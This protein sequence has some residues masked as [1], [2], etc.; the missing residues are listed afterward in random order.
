MGLSQCT[1][2][3]LVPSSV[4]RRPSLLMGLGYFF[5]GSKRGKVPLNVTQILCLWHVS[6]HSW[7]ISQCTFSPSLCPSHTY[8]LIH[9]MLPVPQQEQAPLTIPS[10]LSAAVIV[11]QRKPFMGLSFLQSCVRNSWLGAEL[12]FIMQQAPA[13]STTLRHSLQL[14]SCFTIHTKFLYMYPLAHLSETQPFI[15]NDSQMLA[16]NHRYI[17]FGFKT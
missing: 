17:L 16:V 1:R 7:V 11:A 9:S 12:V 6:S 4:A 13:R 10:S 3:P 15:N 2:I 14:P 5:R 8:T